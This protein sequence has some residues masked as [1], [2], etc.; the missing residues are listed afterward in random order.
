MEDRKPKPP[1]VRRMPPSLGDRM[2]PDPLTPEEKARRRE[3]VRRLFDP[4]PEPAKD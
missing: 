3:N 4:K 2:E 1:G